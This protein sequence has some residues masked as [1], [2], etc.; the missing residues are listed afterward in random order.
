MAARYRGLGTGREWEIAM[1]FD[2]EAF[3]RRFG[4]V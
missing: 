1:A 3:V 4:E 2:G